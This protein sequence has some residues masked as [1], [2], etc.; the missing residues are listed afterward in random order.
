MEQLAGGSLAARRFEQL[1]QAAATGMLAHPCVG[2]VLAEMQLRV[3]CT[4]A[5]G[6][7]L[8]GAVLASRSV[9]PT[10]EPI[11]GR[12]FASQRLLLICAGEC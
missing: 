2:A 9:R 11:L 10:M 5:L 4:V 1:A 7:P 8:C 3:E 6:G 12:R